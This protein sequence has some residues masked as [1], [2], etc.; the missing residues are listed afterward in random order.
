MNEYQCWF[1][2]KGI[3]RADTGAVIITLEGLWHRQAGS[4]DEDPL[5]AIYAHSVCAKDRLKGATMTIEP[6]IFGE[7]D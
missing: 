5:Q 6:S 2:G 1:C 3:E 7:E 4:N